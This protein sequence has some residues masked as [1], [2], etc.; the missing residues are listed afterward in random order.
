MFRGT[1]GGKCVFFLDKLKILC[2]LWKLGKKGQPFDRKVT[3]GFS[4]L[5]SACPEDLFLF[6]EKHFFWRSHIFLSLSL[7]IEKALPFCLISFRQCIQ[8]RSQQFRR[9]QLQKQFFEI[10]LLFYQHRTMSE[11]FSVFWWTILEKVVVTENYASSW[12]EVWLK[13]IFWYFFLWTVDVKQRNLN[14]RCKLFG[15]CVKTAFLLFW[16]KNLM[17][18]KFL[19]NVFSPTVDFQN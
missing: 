4:R 11:K 18:I 1:I 5:W 13:P 7:I 6:F 9:N 8:S 14:L 10:L 2:R 12:Y 19:Q 15:R 3:A 16:S 17:E